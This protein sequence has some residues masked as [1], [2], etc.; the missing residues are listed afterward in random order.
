MRLSLHPPAAVVT[1]PGNR[2]PVRGPEPDERVQG[3]VK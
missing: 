3:Y 1:D 2:Q